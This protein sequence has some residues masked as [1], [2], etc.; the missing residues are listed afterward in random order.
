LRPGD[1]VVR[2]NLAV[3]KTPAVVEAIRFAGAFEEYLPPY[4]PDGDPIEKVVEQNQGTPESDGGVRIQSVAPCHPA[5]LGAYQSAR[6]RFLV[7]IT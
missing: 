5:F 4:S 3:H 2:D 7:R 6:R 1:I